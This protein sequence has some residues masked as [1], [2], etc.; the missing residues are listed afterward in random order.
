MS[1]SEVPIFYEDEWGATSQFGLHELI[2]SCVAD[3]TNQDRWLL[4]DRFKAHPKKSDSKLLA[5][6]RDEIVRW[7]HPLLFAIFDS[8]KLHKLLYS[9]GRP[10]LDEL[11]AELRRRC[12]DPRLHVFL[13]EQNTETVVNA[14]A[15]CVGVPPPDKNKLARDRLLNRVAS[16][17]RQQRDCVRKAVASFDHCVRRIAALTR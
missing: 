2:V 1:H 4:R 9:S 6:C 15:D 5:S 11:H 16:G 10:S 13:L 17:P 7:P 14:T 8:D 12:P 3:E